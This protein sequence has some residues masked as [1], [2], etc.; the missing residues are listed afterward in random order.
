MNY[1]REK[2][3]MSSKARRSKVKKKYSP[4]QRII[5]YCY[6][7]LVRLK[8]HPQE[9]ARGLGVGV[10]AGFFPWFGFQIV[11]AVILAFLVRGNKIAAAM[12]TWGSNPFTYVPIFAF[13]YAVGSWL[14]EFLG[15]SA[16]KASFQ[17]NTSSWSDFSVMGTEFVIPLFIGC[18]VV[19]TLVATIVYF[20]SL[21]FLFRW[22]KL[23][24][25]KKYRKHRYSSK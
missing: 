18:L 7:R 16:D 10:F 21:R 9:I 19:A 17:G 4:L 3:F 12:S 14:V 24:Q 6:Y 13:N 8:G 15:L 2:L 11:V 1:C 23:Q 22:R 5:R 20:S 25:R